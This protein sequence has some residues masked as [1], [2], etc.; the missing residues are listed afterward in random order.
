LDQ[1]N[2]LI[3]FFKIVQR[4]RKDRPP[5]MA[6]KTCKFEQVYGGEE[7]KDERYIPENVEEHDYEQPNFPRRIVKKH[8]IY[9]VGS[10]SGWFK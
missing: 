3:K 8:D 10:T 6:A 5:S 4:V 2:F 9:N 1:L 7:I